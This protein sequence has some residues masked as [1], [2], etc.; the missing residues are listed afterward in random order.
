MS[1]TL[2]INRCGFQ[3]SFFG[4]RNRKK[5]Q[6]NSRV[7]SMREKKMTP[8]I[9][10][11]KGSARLDLTGIVVVIAMVLIT[12]GFYLYQVNDLATKGYEMREA[13]NRIQELEKENKKMQIREV[14][15][16]SMY[17]IEKATQNL[18]MVNSQDITYL[19]S[20]SPVAMK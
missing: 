13:Q 1:R 6:S 9:S 14:E 11:N 3:S 4:S 18:N 8:S 7:L 10:K 2:S 12:G 17:N 19:E 16:R 5:A 20:K 15:L